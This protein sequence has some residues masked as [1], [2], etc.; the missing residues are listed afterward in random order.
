MAQRIVRNCI[1]KN[2]TV[3]ISHLPVFIV[4]KVFEFELSN[5]GYLGCSGIIMFR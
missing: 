4:D 3:Q 2:K 5:F 1:R